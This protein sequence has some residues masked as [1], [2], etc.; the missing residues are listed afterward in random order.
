MMTVDGKKETHHG[1]TE[2]T[3]A[4]QGGRIKDEG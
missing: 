2:N 1:G 3:E 4:R